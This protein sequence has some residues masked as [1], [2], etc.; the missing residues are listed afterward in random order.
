MSEASQRTG[1]QKFCGQRGIR[2]EQEWAD[3]RGAGVTCGSF[4]HLRFL[5]ND[6][7]VCGCFEFTDVVVFKHVSSSI[8][9][10]WSFSFLVQVTSVEERVCPH[11]LSNTVQ[12]ML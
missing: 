9:W 6:I 7:S 4:L 11:L 3:E 5:T 12:Q 1:N 2:G 10:T 8:M